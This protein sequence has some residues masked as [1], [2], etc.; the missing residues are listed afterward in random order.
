MLIEMG[1]KEKVEP[2]IHRGWPLFTLEG[3]CRIRDFCRCVCVCFSS[4]LRFID[5]TV[6]TFVAKV[7]MAR[8]LSDDE[9]GHG[10]PRGTKKLG[11]KG[12]RLRRAHR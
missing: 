6:K 5:D 9:R 2:S 3:L 4:W 12:T 7:G 8:A 1:E 10:A 11:E